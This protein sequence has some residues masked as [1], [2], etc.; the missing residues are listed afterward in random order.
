MG[1]LTDEHIVGVPGPRLSSEPERGTRARSNSDP[2]TAVRHQYRDTCSRT[3][4]E[5]SFAENFFFEND[6]RQPSS[7]DSNSLLRRCTEP[8][9][10]QSKQLQ[11]LSMNTFP[12]VAKR[13][14]HNSLPH[15]LPSGRFSECP[16]TSVN[17]IKQKLPL[18]AVSRAPGSVPWNASV[19]I[20]PWERKR[21]E[22]A[23]EVPEAPPLCKRQYLPASYASPRAR[24][25]AL[26][27][28]L[29][30]ERRRF[31]P[32]RQAL[33]ECVRK[34]LPGASKERC[35]AEVRRI[36]DNAM[37]YEKRRP[38]D[39]NYAV[40]AKPNLSLT[41]RGR[42]Y[43]VYFHTGKFD[44]CAIDGREAWSCCLNPSRSSR[45][46]Q[47]KTVNPDAWHLLSPF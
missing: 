34:Q 29:Q 9:R 39:P 19:L 36:F 6:H 24:T 16:E 13:S 38:L 47:E 25:A 45:G 27:A 23:Y 22:R 3:R 4:N 40:F 30:E 35:W 33:F 17:R 31:A 20:E 14:H 46:C 26:D 15:K 8:L 18:S 2:G 28:E 21:R 7:S 44:V 41:D 42:K 5:Q 12:W 11:Q 10:M 32:E 37:N 43:K 1:L